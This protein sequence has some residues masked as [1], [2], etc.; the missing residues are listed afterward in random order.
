MKQRKPKKTR[1]RLEQALHV[2]D[3]AAGEWADGQRAGE[4]SSSDPPPSESEGEVGD[5]GVEWLEWP[6]DSDRWWFRNEEG[7]FD[8]W[9]E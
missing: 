3:T 8:E 6:V 5:D 1:G 2:V 4:H 9:V 7:H